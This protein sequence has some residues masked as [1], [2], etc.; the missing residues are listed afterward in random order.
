M[1]NSELQNAIEDIQDILMEYGDRVGRDSPKYELASKAFRLITKA[2]PPAPKGA[3]GAV[4]PIFADDLR[5][6]ENQIRPYERLIPATGKSW[7]RLKE[8]LLQ[9]TPEK[10]GEGN[11]SK[12]SNSS[13]G[14]LQSHFINCAIGL[15]GVCNC[16]A[17]KGPTI[18]STTS[19]APTVAPAGVDGLPE[20]GGRRL[21]RSLDDFE[22]GCR[23]EL[24]RLQENHFADN[25]VIS[26][27]CEA[28]RLGREHADY[29]KN[30][31]GWM[32][33]PLFHPAA[34]LGQPAP[35][36][37]VE[38][39]RPMKLDAR[40]DFER[41]GLNP[42]ARVYQDR[43]HEYGVNSHYVASINGDE[44]TVREIAYRINAFEPP[45]SP[46]EGGKP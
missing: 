28:V 21:T 14:Y 34:S 8:R 2:N 7:E 39:T 11:P 19:S 25:S 30:H 42:L 16:A 6:V 33:N 35:A 26:L 44:A 18:V 36:S 10:A 15:G 45:A 9:P 41:E 31:L 37:G 22:Q 17:G 12:S 3:P 43:V 27:L 1:S 23:A 38:K 29:V 5:M 32:P 20:V 13:T 40:L 46:V 4:D 24:L